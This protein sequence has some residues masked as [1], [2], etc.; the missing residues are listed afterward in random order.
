MIDKTCC[1]TGH[2]RLNKS[3]LPEIK[4]NLTKEIMNLISRDV[5]YFGTGGAL[6]FDT[7][8]AQTVINLREKYKQIKLILIIPC[9][10]QENKWNYKDQEVYENIKNNADKIVYLS[11][12]YEDGCMLKRNRHMIDNSNFVIVAWDGR[13]MGGTYYTLNYARKLKKQIIFINLN[14]CF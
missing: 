9:K 7:L 1:F 6:G 10:G 3:Q 5:I 12:K 2:R 4:N 11:E 13:K 14:K 8:A